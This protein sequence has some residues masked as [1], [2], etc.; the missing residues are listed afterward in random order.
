MC[1]SVRKDLDD[2]RGQESREEKN[3]HTSEDA[4]VPNRFVCSCQ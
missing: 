4:T 1:R 2:V 3:R